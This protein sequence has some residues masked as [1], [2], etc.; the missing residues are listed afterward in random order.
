[1]IQGVSNTT[2]TPATTD[3]TTAVAANTA[4]TKTDDTA[5]VYEKSTETGSDKTTAACN[6]AAA[7]DLNTCL[8]Y[9]SQRLYIDSGRLD[10]SLS[11]CLAKLVIICI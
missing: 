11:Q 6:M 4:V 10:Q 8:T 2:Y 3:K 7:L 9:A 1:M 5:A